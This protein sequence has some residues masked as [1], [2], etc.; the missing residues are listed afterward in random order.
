MLS[1][2]LKN[3]DSEQFNNR[4]IRKIRRERYEYRLREYTEGEIR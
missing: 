4:Q 2:L 1:G 3:H